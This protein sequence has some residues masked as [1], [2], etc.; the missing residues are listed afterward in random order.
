MERPEGEVREPAAEVREP[1]AET[2]EAAEGITG[3]DTLMAG[4]PR[5]TSA[6]LLH[7]TEP[8][9]VET[10]P[11]TSVPAVLAGLRALGLGPRDLAHIVVTHIHLDHAGGVGTL[12][13]RFPRALVW[14]HDRGA[15]HLADPTKLVASAGR[16]YGEEVLRR[17]FGPVEPVPADRLRSVSDGDR[18][19]LGDRWLEVLYT[20]GHASHHVA[21]ADSLSGAVFTG[22]ALGIHLP[23]VRVLRPATP[24][25]EVDVELGV[26]SIRRIRERAGSLLLFSHF[27]PVREVDELCELAE[28]RLR[29]W[30]DVVRGALDETEDL[31][32]VVELL[33]R[34]TADELRKAPPSADP[35]RYEV[36]SSVRMNAM[37]LVRYW[38]KRW[39]REAREAG[40]PERSPDN[41]PGPQGPPQPPLGP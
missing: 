9:L 19:R 18:I 16:V 20:P 6:Y 35:E 17:V 32:R 21:L 5:V 7:G 38:K 41:A 8:T 24:P 33:E 2:Y 30:A 12:A 11:A 28:R 31:D 27:G 22:D 10:G 4:H 13:R 1:A 37:G 29:R 14:V 3:V 39:E 25:P 15:P 36:L 26:D 23:E 40:E 34:A